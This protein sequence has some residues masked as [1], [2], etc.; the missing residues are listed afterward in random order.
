MNSQ[1]IRGRE[2]FR[3]ASEHCGMQR[4]AAE[5][6]DGAEKCEFPAPEDDFRKLKNLL[7]VAL[8]ACDARCTSRTA[9][10]LS[11]HCCRSLRFFELSHSG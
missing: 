10:L 2:E 7:R 5:G 8:A 3:N 11:H 6:T 4:R 9:A 1:I